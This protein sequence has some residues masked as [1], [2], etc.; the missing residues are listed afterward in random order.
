MEA[1]FTCFI[2]KDTHELVCYISEDLYPDVGPEDWEIEMDK[3]KKNKKEFIKVES[4]KSSESFK[5]M[6]EFVESLEDDYVKIRL[7]KAIEGRKPFANFKHQIENSGDFRELWFAFRK[8]KN[9][10]W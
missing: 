2:H 9:M 7:L 10:D 1:G 3:I 4:M 8:Q 6:Q 5:I